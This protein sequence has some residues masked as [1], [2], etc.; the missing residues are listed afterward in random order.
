MFKWS[1]RSSKKLRLNFRQTRASTLG[2]GSRI[3]LRREHFSVLSLIW[4]KLCQ[5]IGHCFD[6][7]ITMKTVKHS[8]FNILFCGTIKVQGRCGS[9]EFCRDISSRNFIKLRWKSVIFRQIIANV[10]QTDWG[11]NVDANDYNE[12]LDFS[13]NENE[14]YNNKVLY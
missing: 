4:Q 11:E 12:H 14:K 6:S 5:K 9:I 2:L 1:Q 13:N 7:Q 3:V 8:R 10:T